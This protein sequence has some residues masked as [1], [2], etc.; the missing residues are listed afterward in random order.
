LADLTDTSFPAWSLILSV[1]N[2]GDLLGVGGSQYFNQEHTFLLQRVKGP[3]AA[4]PNLPVERT[5][6]KPMLSEAQ[7]NRLRA[8]L[9]KISILACATED[10]L[11]GSDKPSTE[12]LARPIP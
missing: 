4:T 9:R 5:A 7:Q 3:L 11:K 10:N 6:D 12:C 1:N 2:K 8:T